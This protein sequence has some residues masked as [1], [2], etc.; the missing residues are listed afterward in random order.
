[1]LKSSGA[2]LWPQVIGEEVDVLVSRWQAARAGISSIWPSVPNWLHR[3]LDQMSSA[4]AHCFAVPV[5]VTTRATF[6]RR[7]V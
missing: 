2:V 3:Y 4:H 1:V 7:Q 5:P 6:V